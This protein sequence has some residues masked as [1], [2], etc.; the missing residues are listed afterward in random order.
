MKAMIFSAGYGTR[1]RPLTDKIPKALVEVQGVPLLEHVIVRL[2]SYGFS[3]IIINIHYKGHL[4]REF[5]NSKKNFNISIELSDESEQILDTG[6]GL[7][8]ARDFFDVKPFLLHNVD[9]LNN[10]PLNEL[11][12]YHLLKK[13]LVTLAVNNLSTKK[14]LVFNDQKELCGWENL[15]T[16]VRKGYFGE[17]CKHPFNF[18]GIHVI[19]PKIFPLIEERGVFSII[20]CY[21]RICSGHLILAKDIGDNFWLDVGSHETLEKANTEYQLN[22]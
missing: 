11:Y 4:I 10:I 22:D 6:G 21:L 13:P 2:K 15:D 7:Y 12:E 3:E 18:C 16:G 9:I 17:A 19:D 20:D 8:K 14:H 5:L 1:L